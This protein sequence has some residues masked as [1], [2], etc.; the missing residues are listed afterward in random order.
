[1]NNFQHISLFLA[2]AL[3]ISGALGN[4]SFADD[5]DDRFKEARKEL[6]LFT[7]SSI[8]KA[9]ENYYKV[10]ESEPDNADAYAGLAQS[11]SMLGHYNK[12][13]KK[14]YEDEFNK[15]HTFIVKALKLDS[16]NTNVKR[17]L[18]YYYLHL[19]REKETAKVAEELLKKNSED[20]EAIYQSWAADGKNPDDKRIHKVL[21]KKPELI[22]AHIDLAESYFYR[23]RKFTRAA[24]QISRAIDAKDSSYLR[25][26]LGTIYRNQH[27]YDKSIDEF[28]RSLR[29]DSGFAP[30]VMNYGISLYYKNK[31]NESI[32]QL[33][34]SLDLNPR[35]PET[36]FYLAKNYQRKGD[37]AKS[38]KYY[39]DFIK[40]AAG[41]SKYY[42]MVIMAKQNLNSK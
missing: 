7:P 41:E 30:S 15:A 23:K 22:V 3:L 42:G 12:Q 37:R 27:A 34:R 33:T 24:E 38:N 8:S 25:D 17:A 14:D 18:G 21:D 10:L 31:V 19:S 6:L 36:Y 40:M 26:L 28:K 35:F 29:M 5:N 39:S 2:I 20:Y 16:N 11:Y 32:S 13:I 4:S 9:I 1:M